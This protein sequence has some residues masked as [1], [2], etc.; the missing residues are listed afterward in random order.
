MSFCVKC[1]TKLDDSFKYCPK[2]GAENQFSVFHP[3]QHSQANGNP[4][5]YTG[6]ND[7]AESQMNNVQNQPN[8]NATSNI[9]CSEQFY[10]EAQDIDENKSISV[11]AYFGILFFVPLLV[12]PNSKFARYHANQGLIYLITI[13]ILGV[14]NT[15]LSKLFQ[16]IFPSSITFSPFSGGI[17]SASFVALCS[18]AV[19]AIIITLFIIGIINV[20]KG[21]KK[22]LPV[23][24]NFTIIK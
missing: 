7:F 19:V 13:L 6:A 22:P 23:I 18:S 14:A 15:I 11:I 24:G 20:I 4:P 10:D 16:L 9:D 21:R 2:C 5:K 3:T 12:S 8:D 1:G 17:L